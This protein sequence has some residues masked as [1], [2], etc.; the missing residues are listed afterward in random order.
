MDMLT[1]IVDSR[2]S[3]DLL[4]NEG[5]Q[6]SVIGI[7]PGATGCAVSIGRLRTVRECR[8]KSDW[9]RVSKWICY[10]NSGLVL[11]YDRV[12]KTIIE[13]VHAMP[14]DGAHQAFEFGKNTGIVYGILIANEMEFDLVVPDTWRRAHD[15]AGRK[16]KGT[17]SQ[18]R[19][20]RKRDNAEKAQIIFPDIK[21]TQETADAYLIADYAWRLVYDPGSLVLAAKRNNLRQGAGIIRQET[22]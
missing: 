14:N 19:S 18:Q 20:Q 1:S 5:L 11:G 9:P 17:K 15:L 2:V 12:E 3:V 13:N 4:P 16:Y 10:L 8:F 7:D 22:E 21:I 6:M